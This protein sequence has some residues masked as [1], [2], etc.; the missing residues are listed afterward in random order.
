MTTSLRT[1]PRSEVG[2]S[3]TITANGTNLVDLAGN[4]DD[5]GLVVQDGT[6]LERVRRPDDHRFPPS[7]LL[8]GAM[9]SEAQDAGMI[10]G[11]GHREEA[12][13]AHRPLRP[14]RTSL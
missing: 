5:D 2:S 10:A 13:L 12:R 1:L 3:S 4:L 14:R 7:R 11:A 9:C 6:D 8:L